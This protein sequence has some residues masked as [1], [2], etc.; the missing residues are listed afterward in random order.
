[1]ANLNSTDGKSKRKRI[2]A[3]MLSNNSKLDKG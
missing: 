1:M 3:L 2:K